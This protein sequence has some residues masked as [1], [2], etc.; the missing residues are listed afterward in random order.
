MISGINFMIVKYYRRK[1]DEK[2]G[3]LTKLCTASYAEIANIALA[4]KKISQLCRQNSGHSQCCQMVYF[5]TKNA[6]LEGLA[7]EDVGIL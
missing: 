1:N 2:F 4:F 3:V 5:Q 7:M 6:S